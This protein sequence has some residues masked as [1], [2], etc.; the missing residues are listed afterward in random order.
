MT[1]PQMRWE[2]SFGHLISVIVVI[3]SAGVLWNEM[4]T[5]LGQQDERIATLEARHEAVAAVTTLA[6]NNAN[7]ITSLEETQRRNVE[8]LNA[9]DVRST[10]IDGRLSRLDELMREVRDELRALNIGRRPQQ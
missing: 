2:V 10:Q 5:T 1:F 6:N 7:R 4:H 8:R 3:F 9:I